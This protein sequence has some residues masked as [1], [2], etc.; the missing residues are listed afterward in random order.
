LSENYL[1]KFVQFCIYSL[2]GNI[3]T[4]AGSLNSGN[5][6]L[7][8]AGDIKTSSISSRS[9]AGDG[10]KISITSGSTIDTALG[11]L[12]ARSSSDSVSSGEISLTA[13]GN[14]AISRLTSG[15]SDGNAGN[16]TLF[17]T[18]GEIV[19][20]SDYDLSAVITSGN[21]KL[22]VFGKGN[23]GGE[24]VGI[25]LAGLGDAITPGCLCEGW[26]VAGN[27]IAG[28]ASASNPSPG[29]LKLTAFASTPSTAT[30][31]VTLSTLPSL[32]ITQAYLPAAEAPTA[33]FENRVT[34]TNKGS[35]SI[36]DIRY[37]RAMDWDVPPQEFN[38]YVTISGRQGA[39]NV[40]Y[41][42]N[43]G[44]STVNPLEPKTYIPYYQKTETG[45]YA[46]DENG[47]YIEKGAETENADFV[48]AGS[49]DHGAVFDLGFGSLAGNS[50]TTFS[51]Y[52]GA[53]YTE[54]TAIGA[55]TFV[56]A[57]MFSLGQSSKEG[58]PGTFIF[59]FK[60]VGGKPLGVEAPP[61]LFPEPNTDANNPPVADSDVNPNPTSGSAPVIIA[62]ATPNPLPVGNS[63]VNTTEI[64]GSNSNIPAAPTQNSND[65]SENSSGNLPKANSSLR[66]IN[67][68]IMVSYLFPTDW[69]DYLGLGIDIAERFYIELNYQ[70]GE[71]KDFQRFVN[72]LYFVI[73]AVLASTPGAGGGGLAARGSHEL[74]VAGW[75][76][77]P[78]SVKLRIQQ[79][80]A[81]RMGWS[82]A[83][84]AQ[85]T[86]VFFSMSSTGGGGGSGNSGSR[87]SGNFRG[88]AAKG[89]DW[90]HILDRHSQ[91]G[92][93][94]QQRLRQ[95]PNYID[96]IFENMTDN[97]IKASI[98]RAWK[99]RNKIKT[100]APGP[101]EASRIKYRGYDPETGYTIEIWQNKGTGIIETAYPV[102]K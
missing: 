80:L 101:G 29:N 52:Y 90:E 34:I 33:L 85:M 21:V 76:A 74:A 57:E 10:G 1:P 18:E 49:A 100:Q 37:T 17:S 38:E 51:I 93:I 31:T 77:T 39:K 50:S 81:K 15:T 96:N 97:E 92:R 54:A 24:D 42:S 102:S 32:Q 60:S 66:G 36:S 43:N 63:N 28:G 8:A 75:R 64:N 41:S 13:K 22:G 16:L 56:K 2:T 68:E 71:E 48:D 3:D 6:T 30:S 98:R 78:S 67:E 61:I 58:S 87:A 46:L 35:D 45:E 65:S 91:R 7:D 79:E 89:F 20:N 26:G 70:E 25:Y 73:D 40:L 12:T 99:N 83:K 94:A 55:L 95:D 53:T 59:G 4:T 14:I 82:V 84:A 23:L 88:P 9:A 62:Y 5:V 44:F 19:L 69:L 47:N 72:T 86:N 27:S 11:T